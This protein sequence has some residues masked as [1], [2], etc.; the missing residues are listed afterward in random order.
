MIW[1]WLSLAISIAIA[2]GGYVCGHKQ[3]FVAAGW[4]VVCL[5]AFA[6]GFSIASVL[7]IL[8]P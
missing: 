2:L 8:L 5:G 4:L 3:D 1:K 6:L 7:K